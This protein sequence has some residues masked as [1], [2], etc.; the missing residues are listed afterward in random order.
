MRPCVLLL[1]RLAHHKRGRLSFLKILWSLYLTTVGQA[2]PSAFGPF[3][4]A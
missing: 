2:I 1:V 3:S 4:S